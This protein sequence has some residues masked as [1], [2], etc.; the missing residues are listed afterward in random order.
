MSKI[1]IPRHNLQLGRRLTAVR[2]AAGTSQGAFAESLG[3]SLRAYANYER[4]EREM[5]VALYRALYERYG[6]DPIWLLEGPGEQ[7]VRASSRLVDMTLA[8]QVIDEVDRR[9]KTIHKRIRPEARRRILKAVYALSAE[10]GEL[11]E[12]SEL[13]QLLFVAGR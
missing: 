13:D 2:T 7:P 6:I 12:P 9:L 1:A 10:R 3:L 4:G 5:P 11:V 8:E